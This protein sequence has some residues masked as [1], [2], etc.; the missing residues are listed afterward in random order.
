[1]R[2]YGIEC[3]LTCSELL[4]YLSEP[5]YTGDTVTAEQAACDDLL[6]LHDVAEACILKS[7]GYEVGEGTAAQGC[8]TRA[9][10]T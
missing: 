5:T 4:A 10:P 2:G 1:M 7:K 8:P 3:D 6:S 9:D